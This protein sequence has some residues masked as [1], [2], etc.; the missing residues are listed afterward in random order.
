MAPNQF[1]LTLPSDASLDVYP[2]N[3]VAN[4][5]TKLA[6]T[7][8]LDGQYE[9]GLSEIIFPTDYYNIDNRQKLYRMGTK[10]RYIN[11]AERKSDELIEK[12]LLSNASYS[13]VEEFLEHFNRQ[14]KDAILQH[15]NIS[16]TV[17]A[18]ID[19]N[20]KL[21]FTV[22]PSGPVVKLPD[23]EMEVYF[24][25]TRPLGLRL[26][27]EGALNIPLSVPAR[28]RASERFD[29]YQGLRMMFVYC[30]ILSHS[31]VGNVSAPLLRVCNL[32]NRSVTH[33]S[34]PDIHYKPVQKSQFDNIEISINTED[35][36]L[37]PFQSSKV[38]VTLHFR[39][40]NNL[41]LK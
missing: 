28:I 4:F 20:G 9:V 11:I 31:L 35:A 34:Y 24:V 30:D 15:I 25:I 26:G 39:R 38:L 17:S 14:I 36:Q 22:T 41:L 8:V 27:F 10:V 37:M 6:N 29:L 12:C 2:N 7:V 32:Q 1:Y 21:F 33:I 19:T 5:T 18:D 13:T 3:T 40:I 16:S 23:M